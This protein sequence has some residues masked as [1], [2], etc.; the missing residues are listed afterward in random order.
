MLIELLETSSHLAASV[1]WDLYAG[2]HGDITLMDVYRQVDYAEFEVP[3][4][5]DHWDNPSNSGSEFQ[6]S[7]DTASV[8]IQYN[9]STSIG[10]ITSS[11][12][13]TE[14]LQDTTGSQHERRKWGGL[15]VELFRHGV[16]AHGRESRDLCH[17][18]VSRR[19]LYGQA[20]RVR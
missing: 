4:G 10:A 12:Q 8:P 3:D 13:L 15:F 17:V 6:D 11:G 14:L 2:V 18:Q 1:G 7:T 20:C 9:G 16:S 5:W 19:R